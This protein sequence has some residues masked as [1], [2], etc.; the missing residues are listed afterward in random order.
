MSYDFSY[1][2]ME[3]HVLKYYQYQDYL[4]ERIYWDHIAYVRSLYWD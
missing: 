1:L 4:A 3:S 2:L